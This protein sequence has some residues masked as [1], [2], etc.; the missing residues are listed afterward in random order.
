MHESFYWPPLQL[1]F[2]FDGVICLQN[3][4]AEEKCFTHAQTQFVHKEKGGSVE[5][6]Q[7]YT[8]VQTYN[9]STSRDILSKS[10]GFVSAS[11]VKA[12]QKMK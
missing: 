8:V 11:A 9:L 1:V 7:Q 12:L 4:R 3:L 10:M 2:Y 6:E 5:C